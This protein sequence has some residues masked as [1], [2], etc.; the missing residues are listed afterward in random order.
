M[1]PD[2]IDRLRRDNERLRI[3]LRL[4]RDLA[5]QQQ[6]PDVGRIARSALISAEPENPGLRPCILTNGGTHADA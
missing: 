6:L 4:L 5:D 2:A 1:T 3:A